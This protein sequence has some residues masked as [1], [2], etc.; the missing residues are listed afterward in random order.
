MPRPC[1]FTPGETWHSLF[2][3]LAG[4]HGRSGRVRKVSPPP[5]FDP[6]TNHAVP[7]LIIHSVMFLH[8]WQL[9]YTHILIGGFYRVK[10]IVQRR[11]TFKNLRNAEPSWKLYP[12]GSGRPTVPLR[13]SGERWWRLFGL[14]KSWN[15]LQAK[16]I[17]GLKK[18][19][20]RIYFWLIVIPR[21]CVWVIGLRV[22]AQS[23]VYW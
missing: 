18:K 10:S 13:V 20:W 14:Y 1:C 12:S 4:P 8:C 7:S 15:C 22:C 9:T 2:R 17:S 21:F 5:G 11:R 19:T 16:K 23:S 6:R 3:R